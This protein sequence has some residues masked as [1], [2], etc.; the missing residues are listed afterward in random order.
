MENLDNKLITNVANYLDASD[1]INTMY[2]SKKM[3]NKLISDEIWRKKCE[4]NDINLYDQDPYLLFMR[5][6][7]NN[8]CFSCFEKLDSDYVL[9]MCNCAWNKDMTSSRL[10]YLRYHEDCISDLKTF[11]N[12]LCYAQCEVCNYYKPALRFNGK[13]DL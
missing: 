12:M 5:L 8:K 6:H 11:R 7:Q 4:E 9:L 2:C 3:A 10:R 13:I 1:I